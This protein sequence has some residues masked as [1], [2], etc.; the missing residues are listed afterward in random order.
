[1]L[2]AHNC[3]KDKHPSA[4]YI[5]QR[6]TKSDFHTVLLL[7]MRTSADHF[8]HMIRLLV[9][10]RGP[11]ES[12]RRKLL[13]YQHFNEAGFRQLAVQLIEDLRILRESTERNVLLKCY[14]H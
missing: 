9:H 13:G 1:M 12:P 3:R 6:V 10:G 8:G 2:N 4:L 11:Q 5:K 7:M 14:C